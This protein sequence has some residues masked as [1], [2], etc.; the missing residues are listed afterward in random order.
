MCTLQLYGNVKSVQAFRTLTW[1]TGTVTLNVA[2]DVANVPVDVAVSGAAAAENWGI[3]L[4]ENVDPTGMFVPVTVTLTG[5]VVP[6][7]SVRSAVE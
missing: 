3:C 7:G 5:L 4:R 2:V 6:P 1:P